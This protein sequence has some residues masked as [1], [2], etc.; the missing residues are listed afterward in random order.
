MPSVMCQETRDH[1][2]EVQEQQTTSFSCCLL[3][4]VLDQFE[5]LQVTNSSTLNSTTAIS[6]PNHH[7]QTITSMAEYTVLGRATTAGY[8][9]QQ[10][11][12]T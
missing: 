10:L 11:M 9:D 8:V 7:D 1:L 12:T 6:R 4:V 3:L 5:V 2:R